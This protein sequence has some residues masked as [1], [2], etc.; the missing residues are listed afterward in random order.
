[1]QQE[2]VSEDSLADSADDAQSEDV[3]LHG[4]SGEEDSSDDDSSLDGDILDVKALSSTVKNNVDV[5]QKLAKAKKNA[6]R[7]CSTCRD[8]S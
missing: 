5:Q 1:M 4:F 2:D 3:Y 6:V 8:F 7:P